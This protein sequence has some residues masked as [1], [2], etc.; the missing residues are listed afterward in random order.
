[1][2]VV[3]TANLVMEYPGT[4]AL[5]DVTLNIEPG[6]TGIV[7]VNGAGKSTLIKVLLGLQIPTYGQ[8]EVLGMNPVT[9]GAN[10]RARVGYM[11]E[12]DCLPVDVSAADFL[13]HLAMMS[14]LSRNA[15]RERAADALR[16][17]GLGDERYRLMGGYSTGMKQRVKLAQAIVHDPALVFLDEPTSGLDPRAREDMLELVTKIGEEFGIAVAVTSHLLGELERTADHI[18]VLDAGR[19]VGSGE[20][21]SLTVSTGSVIV[22]AIGADG[23]PGNP[24]TSQALGTALLAKGIPARPY[25]NQVEVAIAD[26]QTVDVIRDTLVELDFGLSRLTERR[27][28]LEEVFHE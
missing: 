26:E 24:I 12:H 25:G 20:T 3:R 21:A 15:A 11:P 28:E 8:I 10:V 1:M 2:A 19:M 27:H 22:D 5:N 7:G 6:I 13:N 14:G 18:I 23:Y 17:V 4:R 16:H 9:D